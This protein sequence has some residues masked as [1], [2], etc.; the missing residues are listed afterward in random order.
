M[1]NGGTGDATPV[2]AIAEHLCTLWG[3]TAAPVFS[4][5]SRAGDPESLIAD[6]Q[7][8][9]ELGFA[10]TLDWRTGLAEYVTWF[11]AQ[12]GNGRA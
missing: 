6:T 2:R 8:Q 7:R 12:R 10:S 1:F 3:V 4:G 9:R 11:K 5:M